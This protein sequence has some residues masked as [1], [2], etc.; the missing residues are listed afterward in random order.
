MRAVEGQL[1]KKEEDY[2]KTAQQYLLWIGKDFQISLKIMIKK[3]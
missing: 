1:G 2:F 3:I